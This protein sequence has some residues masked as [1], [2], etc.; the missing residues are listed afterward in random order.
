MASEEIL[1]SYLMSIGFKIDE[2]GYKKFKDTEEDSKKRVKELGEQLEKFALIASGSATVLTASVLK[3]TDKLTQLYYA[4]QVAGSSARNLQSFKSAAEQVGVSADAAQQAVT[5]LS[6]AIYQNPQLAGVL[7][8][9]NINPDQDKVQVMIELIDKLANLPPYIGTQMAG[10]FGMDPQTFRMLE[11]HRGELHKYYDEFRELNKDTDKQAESSRQFTQRVNEL[12]ARLTKLWQTIAVRLLP[13]GE[14]VVGWLETTV[15]WLIKADAAT[16]GW[17]S[18]LLGVGT[19]LASVLGGLT[20]LRGALGFLG[21]GAAGGTGAGGAAAAAGGV[22]GTIAG[23][24][25][26]I[27]GTAYA[28]Y[29]LKKYWWPYYNATGDA[30][31]KI[32]LHR[33]QLLK[34]QGRL[35]PSDAPM[36]DQLQKKY[37]GGASASV[38]E[39]ADKYSTKYGVDP[40]LMRA[41]LHEEHGT[42][43]QG[44]QKISPKGAIGAAQLMPKTA[45]ALGVDP[46][47]PEQNME[48]G[49]RL[50]SWLLKK[51]GGNESLALAAYN[52]GEGAVDKVH[53]VPAIAETQKYVT[54]ILAYRLAHPGVGSEGGPKVV[55]QQTTKIEVDGAGDPRQVA[56]D[57]LDGQDRVNSDLQRN[58][59]G[60]V[61]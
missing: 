11:M 50:L 4:S 7:R 60:V 36:L 31:E 1:K 6:M 38:N 54:D 20:V 26:A 8:G 46:R 49:V 39:M 5:N 45:A 37:G 57:V 27:A 25:T 24:A 18:R 47:N 43:A 40:A 48:G 59:T 53:S 15:D 30:K 14:E 34:E 13:I 58:V 55:I 12:E 21:I 41:L 61:R 22:S 51:Y 23:G 17:S 28:A 9:L 42:D 44:N 16:N 52:A 10:M 32:Q 3:I 56:K 33:L 29:L 35:D 19:A 2:A